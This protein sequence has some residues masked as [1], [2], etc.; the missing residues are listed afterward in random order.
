MAAIIVVLASVLVSTIIIGCSRVEEPQESTVVYETIEVE[1]VVETTV[2]EQVEVPVETTVF[3]TVEVPVEVPVEVEKQVIVE[4]PKVIEVEKP[5][6]IEVPTIQEIIKE[7]PVEVPVE[8]ETTVYEVVY[9]TVELPVEVQVIKE[10][11][12]EVEKQHRLTY[13]NNYYDAASLYTGLKLENVMLIVAPTSN[14]FY[15]LNSNDTD[16]ASGSWAALTNTAKYQ[17]FENNKGTKI[18]N[19]YV[20]IK[21]EGIDNING[22]QVSNNGTPISNFTYSIGVADIEV[23]GVMYSG[24]VIGVNDEHPVTVIIKINQLNSLLSEL[25]G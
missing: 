17:Q 18:G 1:K 19:N 9:E 15:F 22:F 23:L 25:I 21:V 8:V 20:Q 12:V 4:V 3:E 14:T 13:I 24:E 16:V 10:V 11:K 5:V 7:V 2:Y 6:V